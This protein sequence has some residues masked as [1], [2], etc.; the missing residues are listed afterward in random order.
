VPTIAESGLPG[1]EY[2]AWFGVFAPGTTPPDLV[3]RLVALFGQALQAPDTREKLRS[4]G[5]ET[6]SLSGAPFRDKVAA[7]IE[8]WRGVIDKAGIKAIQ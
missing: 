6:V 1:Y 4:Q 8:R 5:V 3:A 2:V 7:E